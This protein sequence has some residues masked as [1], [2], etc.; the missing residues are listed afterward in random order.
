MKETTAYL[1]KILQEFEIKLNQAYTLP[2]IDFVSSNMSPIDSGS[3]GLF[4]INEN[5][6]YEDIDAIDATQ[7]AEIASGLGY[8]T[9]QFWFGNIVQTKE[10]EYKFLKDSLAT[11][12]QYIGAEA[13]LPENDWFHKFYVHNSFAAIAIDDGEGP[14]PIVVEDG[15]FQSDLIL[16]NKVMIRMMKLR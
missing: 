9:S 15:T 5:A 10:R 6:L 11:Y 4:Y 2:K 1:E 3:M 13:A 16:K 12:F 7:F 8:P 14:P